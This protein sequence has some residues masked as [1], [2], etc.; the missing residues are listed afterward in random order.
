MKYLLFYAIIMQSN[1]SNVFNYTWVILWYILLGYNS[2][3]VF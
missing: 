3:F 1:F 2:K